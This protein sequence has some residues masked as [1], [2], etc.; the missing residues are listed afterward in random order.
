LAATQ[1]TCKQVEKHVLTRGPV[2]TLPRLD[3]TIPDEFGSIVLRCQIHVPRITSI[4]LNDVTCTKILQYRNPESA[5][6]P[7]NRDNFFST[8]PNLH[9][10]RC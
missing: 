4:P 3:L 5:Q 7:A 10:Y 2:D 8:M 6:R 1:L 9:T